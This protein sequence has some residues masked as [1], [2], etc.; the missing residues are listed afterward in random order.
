MSQNF[1]NKKLQNTLF[2][3]LRQDLLW[4]QFLT[5]YSYEL[6]NLE[7]KYSLIQNNWN[8]YENDKNNVIRIN[9]SFGYTPN[10]AINNTIEMAINEAESIPY[11]IK[12]K[13]T[14]YGYMMIL[15][16]MGLLGELYNYYWNNSKLIKLIDFNKTLNNIKNSNHYTPFDGVVALQNYITNLSGTDVKLDDLIDP[17]DLHSDVYWVLDKGFPLWKLDTPYIKTPTKHLGLEIFPK[18]YY[19]TYQT[20]LGLGEENVN[21]YECQI[22]NLKYYIP[23]SMTLKINGIEFPITITTIDN[24]E[25]FSD[26]NNVLNSSDSYFNTIENLVHL[27][28]NI[29][30]DDYEISV[31]YKI[32]LLLSSDYF[33]YLENGMDYNKRNAIV[34]HS[35][36]FLTAEISQGK[37][38]D[39]FYPNEEGYTI[40]DL[41]LKAVTASAYNRTLIVSDKSYLDYDSMGS[42]HTVYKLDSAI[43]WFLDSETTETEQVSKKIKYIAV[44]NKVLNVPNN[45][46]A[47]IFSNENMLFYYNLNSE[48]DSNLIYDMSQNKINCLVTGDCN[49]IDSVIGKSLNFNGETF[50]SS[51]TSLTVSTNETY[52]FGMWFN[53]NQSVDYD[54]VLFDNFIKIKY[55]YESE[56]LILDS[57]EIDCTPNE[58]HFLVINFNSN[59]MDVYLDNE[60]VLTDEFIIS[61]TSKTI[62][63]GCDSDNTNCFKGQIDNLWL[64]NK[65]FTL[66]NISYIYNNKITIISHMGNRLAYYRIYDDEIYDLDKNYLL[67]QSYV[68]TNDVNNEILNISDDGSE[69]IV[70]QTEF[71]PIIPSYFTISYTD[72]LNNEVIINSDEDGNFYKQDTIQNEKIKG[73]IDFSKG[74]WTLYKDTIKSV[75]QDKIASPIINYYNH[76]YFVDDLKTSNKDWYANYDD[77]NDTF[78]NKIEADA[79]NY[80]SATSITF[81][82]VYY[83]DDDKSTTKQKIYNDVEKGTYSISSKIDAKDNLTAWYIPTDNDETKL[84]SIDDGR[85]VYNTI[86]QLK[87]DLSDPTANNQLQACTILGEKSGTII[88]TNNNG[89]SFYKNVSCN[90]GESMQ[91]ITCWKNDTNELAYKLGS[92]PAY[93]TDLSFTTSIPSFT[94]NT[95]MQM[96]PIYQAKKLIQTEL[97]VTP[98]E[99]RIYYEG[100]LYTTNY[101]QT[102]TGNVTKGYRLD[103]IPN[104]IKFY[105]WVKEEGEDVPT[106]YTGLVSTDGTVSGYNISAGS[107]DYTEN[108]LYVN[109][110]NHIE[111]DLLISYEYTQNLNIN[112]SKPIKLNYK[113]NN[114]VQINEI[115]L[116]DSNHELLA[117]MTFPNVEPHTINDNISC[118]FAIIKN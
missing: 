59:S 69:N 9:N 61:S 5:A 82:T 110:I 22:E 108:I 84:Y 47:N 64:L 90:I 33:Y 10:L 50:A 36:L 21:E 45:D 20:S 31:E 6:E 55:D 104:T 3:P 70:S 116:E 111:S 53:A 88:Y 38:S 105:Y 80:D 87:T 67:V 83:E 95:E 117:Y 1:I 100:V 81:V 77:E 76:L 7:N 32:N 23:K 13:S 91:Q 48:N 85:T 17:H 11:R 103:L 75:S 58:N 29:I 54:E 102:F 30:P 37:G 14:Y 63:I 42:G 40:P 96:T 24:K 68:K 66:E 34:P 118:M 94:S 15:K 28:F 60:F 101:I 2:S 8:I 62:Y 52:C 49:K 25:F 78:T 56:K 41:K 19:C 115:G 93:Y 16:Q 46:N 72:A 89:Q 92:H 4:S 35:G 43:K 109:F 98:Q 74:I 39:F 86:E 112:Y 51:I 107:F 79:E 71:S 12:Y 44:G 26:E 27:N 57:I 97:S 18:H 65:N 99:S 114:S 73:N 113:I 106:K